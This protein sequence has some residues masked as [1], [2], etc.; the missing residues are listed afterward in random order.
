MKRKGKV[1]SLMVIPFVAASLVGCGNS[2]SGNGNGTSG[3]ATK[4]T[5]VVW[6]FFSQV[7]LLAQ[8]FEKSHPNV[9]VE[10]KVFP[11]DQYETKLQTALQTGS[12]VPDVF[13]LERSYIG[14]FINTPYV[15]NMSSMGANSLVK[16][17]VPYVAALGEDKDGNVRAIADSSSP[18]GLMYR[19]AAAKKWL[20]TDD[21]DKISK[22]VNT[23]P[24][25]IALGEK[26]Y[27]E[28]DGKVH[29]LDN[30][31]S[32]SA[33]MEY[34]MEPWVSGTK[35][36]IDPK[37]NNV[38]N[39]ERE[40]KADNVEAELPGFSAGWG[41][42]LNDH[43]A[44]GSAIMF[45]IPSWSTDSIDNTNNKAKG[46]YGVASAPV[47]Y[48]EGG[49]YRAIYSKSPNQKLAYEFVKFD[50]SQ[51]WQTWN[52]K[53]TGNMPSDISVYKKEMNTYKLP[54]FGNQDL[55]KMYYNISMAIPAR[56]PDEYSEE[57]NSLF[58]NIVT[59]MLDQHKTNQWAFAQLKSQVKDEFPQLQ[60]D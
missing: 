11:G 36:Q 40:M 52:L 4:Q 9:D 27:K 8:Q 16:G 3:K 44:N 46:Q 13:D 22:M 56:K 32:V 6:T 28:S 18:G 10:V 21:P 1:L 54:E 29:L 7:K 34:N 45:G 51:Q 31:G 47:G 58:G 55:L 17:M 33:I 42:A 49:T 39:T 25:M 57:I 20:G 60:V 19:R 38:L 24:K 2:T 53:N 15:A 35:L 12:N 50:A 26:V 5:L 59:Q 48:Y 41:A 14:Q 43:S 37:W 30:T 23:W